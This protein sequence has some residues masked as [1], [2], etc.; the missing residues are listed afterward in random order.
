[1]VISLGLLSRTEFASKI[2]FPAFGDALYALMMYFIVT[3]FKPKH[4]PKNIFIIAVGIC[5]FIELTQLYQANWINTIRSYKIA[6]L[7][8]G[9]GFLYT[10][11]L[12][13]L[14]GGFAGFITETLWFKFNTNCN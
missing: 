10:D 7:V 2:I 4:S 13:Y 9:H 12:A 8:L 11:L 3:F 14:A 1:M 5:F 6:A